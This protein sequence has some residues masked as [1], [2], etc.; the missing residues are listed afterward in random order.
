MR[1]WVKNIPGRGHS[2]DKGPEARICLVMQGTE[3]KSVS[4][5][6]NEEREE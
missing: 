6:W 4:V 2:Q 1:F 3:E 5:T